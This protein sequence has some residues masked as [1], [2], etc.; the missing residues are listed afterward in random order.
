MIKAS[1]CITSL[2][3]NARST[4]LRAKFSIKRYTSELKSSS[5]ANNTEFSAIK[6]FYAMLINSFFVNCLSSL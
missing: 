6:R 1:K 2:K 5:F 4:Q 3:V